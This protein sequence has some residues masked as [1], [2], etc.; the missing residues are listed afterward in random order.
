MIASSFQSPKFAATFQLNTPKSLQSDVQTQ[1]SRLKGDQVFW[2]KQS[3]SFALLEDHAQDKFTVLLSDNGEL[4]VSTDLGVQEKASNASI[5]GTVLQELGFS[6][7][8]IQ[9]L[10][11]QVL[12]SQS[13]EE[14]QILKAAEAE[15]PEP[16]KIVQI[17]SEAYTPSS[18]L[19]SGSNPNEKINGTPILLKAVEEGDFNMFNQLLKHSRVNINLKDAS[20]TTALGRASEKGLTAFVQALLS[21]EDILVNEKNEVRTNA[22]GK[23]GGVT[24]LYQAACEGHAGLVALLLS[25]DDVNVDARQVNGWLPLQVAVNKGHY[26]S[27]KALLDSG[28]VTHQLKEKTPLGRS[29]LEESKAKG[30]EDIEKLLRAYGAGKPE[31]L[32]T[33]RGLSK[34]CKIAIETGNMAAF[35]TAILHPKF[36]PRREFRNFDGKSFPLRYAA[37]LG[38]LNM[39]E[40]LLNLPNVD[41][42]QTMSWGC[43]ALLFAS[44]NGHVDVVKRLLQ[45]PDINVNQKSNDKSILRYALDNGH[46]EVGSLLRASGARG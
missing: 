3:D 29:I 41:V 39:V 17:A 46:K 1:Y 7:N 16:K 12:V 13:P 33:E 19:A 6:V 44:E 40:A 42:N 25:H 15:L 35:T 34:E 37:T 30:Y 32:I 27:V 10:V 2:T 36:N 8:L 14:L 28:K 45:I 5:L 11:K 4:T 20:G 23:L 21:R 38:K 43:S 9:S 26:F 18:F 31:R 22:Q 24:P